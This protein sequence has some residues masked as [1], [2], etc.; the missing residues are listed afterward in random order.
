MGLKSSLLSASWDVLALWLWSCLVLSVLQWEVW[1]IWLSA[2]GWE[3]VC[4][5]APETL[6]VLR[7]LWLCSSQLS[8]RLSVASVK[9]LLLFI[10]SLNTRTWKKKITQ[11]FMSSGLFGILDRC[12]CRQMLVITLYTK[13]KKLLPEKA[14]WTGATVPDWLFA[15]SRYRVSEGGFSPLSVFFI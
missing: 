12:R 13:G 8:L 10:P 3:A 4:A 11:S 15:T 2:Q 7:R 9:S 1:N 5:T 14:L 6:S